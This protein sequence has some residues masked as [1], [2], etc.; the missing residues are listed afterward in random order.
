MR[1]RSL[2]LLI[3]ANNRDNT[4]SS[5]QQ[6]DVY[7][8]DITTQRFMLHERL[9]TNRVEDVEIFQA[10]D[11]TGKRLG[12]GV[13]WNIRTQSFVLL[14][15]LETDNN[16]IIQVVSPYEE[17]LFYVITSNFRRL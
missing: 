3:F 1:I 2:D 13:C 16:S 4:V 17:C 7:R 6:S 11:D 9:E 14:Q 15:I 8:W 12:W 10:F 5:P